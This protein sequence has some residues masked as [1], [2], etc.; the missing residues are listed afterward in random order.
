MS[1]EVDP[2]H[3]PTPSMLGAGDGAAFHVLLLCPSNMGHVST[4]A[5]RVSHPTLWLGDEEVEP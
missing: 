3:G 1:G 2:L 5:T 4:L